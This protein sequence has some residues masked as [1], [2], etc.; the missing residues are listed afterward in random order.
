MTRNFLI[1]SGLTC[2]FSYNTMM[3]KNTYFCAV[4]A[5]IFIY[6]ANILYYY[7]YSSETPIFYQ[8]DL[9]M[10][11]TADATGDK[12]IAVLSQS[13]SG[14]NAIN[15]LIAFYDIHERK[16]EVLFF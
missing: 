3:N 4:Y 5:S 15:P 7:R 8:N 1:I 11:N 12:P 13:I 14:L 2:H 6:V 10:R 9:A 16:R